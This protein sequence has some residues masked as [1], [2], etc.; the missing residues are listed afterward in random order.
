WNT[1]GVAN[2][3]R[4]SGVGVGRREVVTAE[5]AD[6][7]A[8]AGGRVGFAA[9][10]GVED[11]LARVLARPDC[12]VARSSRLPAHDHGLFRFDKGVVGAARTWFGT[13]R[14]AEEIV[15][16]DGGQTRVGV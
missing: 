8:R 16:L 15:L 14:L 10:H 2:Y 9:L 12:G 3:R 7:H 5:E 11:R 1:L 4:A 6:E 13:A